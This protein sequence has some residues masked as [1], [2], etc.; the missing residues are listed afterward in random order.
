MTSLCECALLHADPSVVRNCD[1]C[2]TTCCRSCAV[3]V[4][5]HAYC[6]W[7]ATALTLAVSA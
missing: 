1:D 5:S 7:C 6:R 2:G 4:G 3:E